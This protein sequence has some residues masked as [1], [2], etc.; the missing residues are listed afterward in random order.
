MSKYI[1]SI[2]DY[3]DRWCDRCP[4]RSKCAFAQGKLDISEN[5]ES[6][7]MLAWESK[8]YG[9]EMDER[10]KEIM[11]PEKITDV[12][13]VLQTDELVMAATEFKNV[14]QQLLED[15]S[16]WTQ[17][18]RAHAHET[19]SGSRD[20]VE[21]LNEVRMIDKCRDLLCWD[22]IFIG[23]KVR[24]AVAGKILNEQIADDQ[25]DSNGS[26]K[27]ALISI[28]RSLDALKTI[29]RIKPDEDRFLVPLSLLSKINT[30]TNQRFPDAEKFV[31]PGFDTEEHPQLNREDGRTLR[32][33]G[34][35]VHLQ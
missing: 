16:Y 4:F 34:G 27:V 17:M 9:L 7:K 13:A 12:E 20:G 30:L 1:A 32:T 26:A 25:N 8:Q 28:G 18:A 5:E 10:S 24:R 22:F 15:F 14:M 11:T 33:L 21:V 29:F 2:H 35:L 3:C 19:A 31:R 23:A 6:L